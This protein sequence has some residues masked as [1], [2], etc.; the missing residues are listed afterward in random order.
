MKLKVLLPAQVLV[1]EE[2]TKVVAKAENGSFGLLPRH[3]DIVAALAPGL[4]SFET[5]NGEEQFLAVD[6]G[7]LVKRGSEVQIS[8]RNAVRGPDLGML[9]QAVIEKFRTLDAQEKTARSALT[10]LE[11]DFVRRFIA[12]EEHKDGWRQ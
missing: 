10:K 5:P 11:A 1:D 4:L 9:K 3:I 6:R 7:I 12:L 8:T 2:V